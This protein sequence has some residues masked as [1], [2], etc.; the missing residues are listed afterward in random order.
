VYKFL[1]S[2]NN[3]SNHL[4]RIYIKKELIVL[5]KKIISLSLAAMIAQSKYGIEI[6]INWFINSK[7][8]IFY[9]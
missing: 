8:F 4:D 7:V 1:I 5:K 2:K 9:I 6:R 3:L